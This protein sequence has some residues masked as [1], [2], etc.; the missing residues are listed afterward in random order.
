MSESTY[1]RSEG[2]VVR[3]VL[4]E[5]LL[6]PASGRLA[7]LQ[8]VFTLNDTAMFVWER[9]DGSRDV[10]GLAHEVADEFETTPDE[11]RRDVVGFIEGLEQSGL[12]VQE[13]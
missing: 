9:L 3:K 6:V 8:Q 13:A 4:D 12:V 1:R 5:C 10:D 7:D 11:A 2:V